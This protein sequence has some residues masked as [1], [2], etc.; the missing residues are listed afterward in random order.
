MDAITQPGIAVVGT[1][2]PTPYGLGMAERLACDL[3]NRG[4]VIFSG[5]ARGV[6]AAAHR[7]AIHAKGKTVAVFGTG[8]DI[9][10][11]KENSR[12]T[13]QMLSLGGALTP[14]FP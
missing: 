10:Y 6:D 5:L 1:R 9:I 3:V 12:I 14:N 13:E 11:P 8:V 2:H 4:L 7:G